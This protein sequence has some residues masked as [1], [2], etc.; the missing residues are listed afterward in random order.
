MGGSYFELIMQE[1]QHQKQRMDEMS[2]ENRELRRQLAELRN[3]QGIF[4]NIE[5]TQFALNND[6]IANQY[7]AVLME[8]VGS[9]P[10]TAPMTQSAPVTVEPTPVTLL[11]ADPMGTIPETPPPGTDE[12]MQIPQFV[13]ELEV[14]KGE[15]PAG[16]ASTFL[17]DL[18]IDEFAAAATSP[19][20]VWKAPSSAPVTRKL[21]TVDIDDEAQKAALRKELIG[22]FLLE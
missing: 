22:S 7:T 11:A 4:L 16:Y 17:E 3:G 21:T 14:E 13:D 1:V 20:A 12:F 18:L 6:D 2:A 19:I 9:V 8:P 15:V 10:V 5:G